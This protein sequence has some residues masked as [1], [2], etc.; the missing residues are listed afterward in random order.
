MKWFAVALLLS[1]PTICSCVEYPVTGKDGKVWI[2]PDD[3]Q[4][5]PNLY[6]K[7]RAIRDF[8]PP[9]LLP[10]PQNM[11][12]LQRPRIT[13]EYV[14]EVRHRLGDRL[15]IYSKE[16]DNRSC[17]ERRCYGASVFEISISIGGH[18]EAGWRQIENPKHIVLRGDRAIPLNPDP[19][20]DLDWGS[21]PL[22]EPIRE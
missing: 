3:Y 21:E 4:V 18:V 11:P 19:R 6:P 10:N 17:E 13:T 16:Y 9:D 14:W 15:W 22:F 8:Q 20:Y 5:D 12:H 1:M 7:Y 2:V